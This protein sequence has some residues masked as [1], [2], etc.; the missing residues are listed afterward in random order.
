MI[1][2]TGIVEALKKEEA[3]TLYFKE[4]GSDR[5]YTAILKQE[6]SG[7]VVN[8]Q[9]GRRGN[10]MQNGT[11]TKTPVTY[12]EAKKIYDKLIKSKMGEGYTPGKTD[13]ISASAITGDDKAQRDTGTRPQLLNPIGEDVLEQYLTNDKYGAQEKY[14]GKR[15]LIDIRDGQ[16]TGINRKGLAVELPQ[17]IKDSVSGLQAETLDGELIGDTYYTF[18]LLRHD[19]KGIYTWP[20]KKRYAELEKLQFGNNVIVGPLAIGEAEK[21]TMYAKLKAEKKE[22]MVFKDLSAPYKAGRPASGGTQ[23]KHK[24]WEST[25]ARVSKLNQKHSV[26]LE[27]LDDEGKNYVGVGNVTIPPNKEIPNVGEMVEIKYLYAYRGGSLYQP[28]YL[29]V[30]DDKDLPDTL[31]QLKYKK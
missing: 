31:S 11:K 4:G 1:K 18:D 29:G 8:A 10:T 17:E 24:F 26:A 12:E 13:K 2:L 14:D 3:V 19:G 27:L 23:L 20:Y 9:W 22:G 5:V 30:R 25:T 28:Q 16:A 6:G 15:I 7:W 21:R